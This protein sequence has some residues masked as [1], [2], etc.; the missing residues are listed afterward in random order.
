MR[1]KVLFASLLIL[2]LVIGA[3]VPRVWERDRAGPRAPAGA[4][5]KPASAPPLPVYVHR[6]EPRA[7]TE[8]IEANGTL[9]AN[10]SVELRSEISGRIV[11]IGFDEGAAIRAGEVLVKIN[12]SELQA[13]LR[14]THAR[15]DLARVQEARQRQLIEGGGTS[16][17]SFDAAVNEVR[18]LQAEADLIRAQLDKTEVRAPFDGRIGRRFVSVGSYLTPTTT[19][20]TLQDIDELKLDFSI[21]ER[22]MGRVHH[23]T[24][25]EFTAAG[26]TKKLRGEVYA[27]EPA[28]DTTTRTIVIRARAPNPDHRLLPGAYAKVS[29]TL[30]EIPDALMV[31]TTAIVPGLN[32]R[33]LFVLENGRAA[34]RTV[35]TGIR[36]DREVQIVDG[37]KPHELVITSGLLQLRDGLP[38][39]PAGDNNVDQTT[40]KETAKAAQD[41]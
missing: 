36:L 26:G 19:I 12:D 16:R 13:Q 41:S 29:V 7:L 4:A 21:S 6:V 33:T 5:G 35:E 3:I 15:I 1:R 2:A 32:Q 8:T 28:I 27:V 40:I 24:R 9:L 38:V 22:H 14:Q 30:D 39:Q 17:E 37:V 11:R 10:E 18:V 25:I 20:A 31:P 34:R 23:G